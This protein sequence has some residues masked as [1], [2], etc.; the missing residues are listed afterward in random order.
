MEN[1]ATTSN[2]QESRAKLSGVLTVFQTPFKENGDLDLETIEIQ[3][4]WL[5]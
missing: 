5:G 4:D 2:T 3:F 1:S